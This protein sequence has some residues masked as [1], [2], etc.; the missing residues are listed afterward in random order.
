MCRVYIHINILLEK[1]GC[2]YHSGG[3]HDGSRSQEFTEKLVRE[4][5][6]YF[7]VA[8]STLIPASQSPTAATILD[9]DS[10]GVTTLKI[11]N[12]DLNSDIITRS[13]RAS[14]DFINTVTSRTPAVR[15]IPT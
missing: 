14:P 11:T 5:H 12:S 7:E 15:S 6:K 13:L 4:R 8:P 2:I 1:K 9:I 3:M 10:H